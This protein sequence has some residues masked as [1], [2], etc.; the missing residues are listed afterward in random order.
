[1]TGCVCCLYFQAYHAPSCDLYIAAESP[2]VYRLNL[3]HGQ[4]LAP[5]DT[6]LDS[7]NALSIPP[8][9]ELLAFGGSTGVV[10]CW[11]PRARGKS[12]ELDVQH[13]LR[14]AGDLLDRYD[15]ESIWSLSGMY[16]FFF[17]NVTYDS[18]IAGPSF[19]FS[20]DIF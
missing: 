6:N 12:G 5:F 18:H 8:V 16:V 3:E 9:H 13:S 1:M 14:M 2:S 17:E 11:D 19:Q 10:E 20:C 4:Y 15:G 7:V